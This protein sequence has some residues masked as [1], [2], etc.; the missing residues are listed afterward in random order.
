MR[1]QPITRVRA[2]MGVELDRK[3]ARDESG[4][5]VEERR[6]CRSHAKT[7]R[8]RKAVVVGAAQLERR[9]LGQVKEGGRSERF[10]RGRGKG[11]T[12]SSCPSCAPEPS[13]DLQAVWLGILLQKLRKM[14]KRCLTQMFSKLTQQ[15]VF[16]DLERERENKK[17]DTTLEAVDMA[18]FLN[19]KLEL[20]LCI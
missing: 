10:W 14:E 11:A 5:L 15:D 18:T 16:C 2:K 3:R 1:N 4:R 12:V 19:S 8:R 13:W 7:W 9:D 17:G 20:R 6:R